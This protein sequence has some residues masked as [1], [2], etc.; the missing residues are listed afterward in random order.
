MLG[1]Y[2][3]LLAIWTAQLHNQVPV[4]TQQSPVNQAFLSLSYVPEAASLPAPHPALQNSVPPR[5][6]SSA[7]GS[8][9]TSYMML[10]V[11]SLPSV[12]KPVHPH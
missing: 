8:D 9:P 10:L 4:Y 1:F 3:S 6:T 7:S 11:W 12:T 5:G 2:F